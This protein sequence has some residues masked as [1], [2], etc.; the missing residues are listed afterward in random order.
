MVDSIPSPDP[1]TL[2]PPLLACLAAF[3]SPS[4]PPALLPLLSPILRQRVQILSSVSQSPSD[5]W[6]RLLCWGALKA[7]RLQNII[8]TASFEPHPV[9]GEIEIPDDDV[10]VSYKRLDPETL[11]SQLPLH[12]HNITVLYVWCPTDQEGGGPGWRVAEVLPGD[13]LKDEVE[14]WSKSIAEANEY[15]QLKIL[16]EA[17]HEAEGEST[18]LKIAQPQLKG[19]EQ[20]E[21]DDDDYWAQYDNTPGRTPLQQSPAPNLNQNGL[22]PQQNGSDSYFARYSEVQPALDNVDLSINPNEVGESTLNGDAIASIIQRQSE[23]VNA[24]KPNGTPLFPD[25]HHP[26]ESH[27]PLSHP[28]PSSAS[29]CGSDAVSKLE[30]TAENQSMAEMGVKHHISSNIKSLFRL[31]RTTGISKAEFESIVK[32]ELDL[33]SL[34]ESDDDE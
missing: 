27:I 11:R 4:P 33:L 28:R 15:R 6:L 31:A 1:Q 12:E 17:V 23:A 21:D 30:Q 24:D 22:G 5:P 32:K 10:P 19:P 9:S 13:S 7:E 14:T 8:N 25:D 18:A 3:A 29:S 16:R 20:E 2:L 26:T 34:V